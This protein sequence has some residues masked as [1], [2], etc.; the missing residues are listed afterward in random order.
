MEIRRRVAMALL[1]IARFGLSLAGYA[2]LIAKRHPGSKP[3]LNAG[4]CQQL[5]ELLS[6]GARAHGWH[7]ALWTLKRMTALIAHHFGLSYCPSGIWRLLR[8]CKWSPQKPERRA[9]ERDEQAMAQWPVQTWPQLTK[10]PA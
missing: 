9:R 10:S 6:Q 2:G 8:R 1:D 3:T 4:Q 7:N 5:L